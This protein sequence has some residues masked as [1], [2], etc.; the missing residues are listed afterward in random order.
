MAVDGLDEP[1]LPPSDDEELERGGLRLVG[2]RSE[3]TSSE[4]GDRAS[5]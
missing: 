1:P 2:R 3:T 4:G 5:L